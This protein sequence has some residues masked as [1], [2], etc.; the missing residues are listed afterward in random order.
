M[1]TFIK[2]PDATLDYQVDWSDW[3]SSDTIASVSWVV[4]SGITNDSTANTTTTATIWLSG[5]SLGSAYR[6]VCRIVTA[7]GRTADRTLH[8]KVQ[9]K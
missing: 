8:I 1:Q 9:H 5:G 2:D 3:L 7:A 6:V 4:P